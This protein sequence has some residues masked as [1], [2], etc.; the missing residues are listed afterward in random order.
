MST[1]NNVSSERLWH[2]GVNELAQVTVGATNMRGSDKGW[3]GM[4]QR[5]VV[6]MQHVFSSSVYFFIHIS[7][8]S[9]VLYTGL[10]CYVMS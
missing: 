1:A 9:V 7:L 6:L 5:Y 10:C 8:S 3:S 4:G 2:C